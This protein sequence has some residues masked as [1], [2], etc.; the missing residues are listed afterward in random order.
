MIAFILGALRPN[1]DLRN[2]VLLGAKEGGNTT[3]NLR[4]TK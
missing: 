1:L 2:W 4:S 3:L